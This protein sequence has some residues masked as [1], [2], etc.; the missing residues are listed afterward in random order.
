MIIEIIIIIIIIIIITM[1][2]KKMEV[3]LQSKL[4]KINMKSTHGLKAIA[5][6]P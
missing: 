3:F 6:Y 5:T 4:S 1:M 2:M